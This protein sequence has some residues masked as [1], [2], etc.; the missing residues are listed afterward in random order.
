MKG[1]FITFEGCEGVGKSKQVNL[2][3]DYLIKTNQNP[4]ILREPGSTSISEG[5]RRVILNPKNS[6]MSAEC[7]LILYI[8]ARAQLVREIIRPALNAGRLIIS[9]RF[10]DS[11]MAY[12]G[13][14][15][16]LGVDMVNTLNSIA[17]AECVPDCTIFL[18]LEPK[19][20]FKRKGG[21]DLDDRLE[22]EDI[23]FHNRVYDGYKH[24]EKMNKSRFINIKPIGDIEDTHLKIITALQLRG[25]IK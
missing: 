3:S 20:A 21:R 25:M 11:S 15:R 22:L 23:K 10:I 7:E 14:G 2:L 5:I 16:G 13:F 12:Q 19:E 18:D 24:A 6:S 8:A 4:L 1:K 9:D 17:I